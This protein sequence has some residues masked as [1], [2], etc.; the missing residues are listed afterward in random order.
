MDP[1]SDINSSTLGVLSDDYM[2]D[3]VL[4]YTNRPFPTLLHNLIQ[5]NHSPVVRSKLSDNQASFEGILQLSQLVPQLLTCE[6]LLSGFLYMAVYQSARRTQESA[7]R[8]EDSFCLL[9]DKLRR[10]SDLGSIFYSRC[11]DSRVPPNHAKERLSQ[12]YRL[13]L[14]FISAIVDVLEWGPLGMW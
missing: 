12:A 7:G 8:S 13:H 11:S 6:S 9:I 14:A 10:C 3:E 1:V 5:D 2:R 4:T